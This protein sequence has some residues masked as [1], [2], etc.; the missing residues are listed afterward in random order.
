M[1]LIL[2]ALF[3]V[4]L[5]IGSAH[6]AEVFVKAGPPPVMVERQSIRPSARHVWIAGYYRWNGNAYIW[7]PG[8]W[9]LP[10][11]ANAV[12]VAARWR[13]RLE[14]YTFVEGRWR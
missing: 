12:W 1:K 13:H 3:G 2:T 10:P 5:G 8:G 11:R 9:G 14:G 6:A 4:G 7:V